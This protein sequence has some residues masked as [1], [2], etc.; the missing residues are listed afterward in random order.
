M[1]YSAK[2]FKTSRV[3]IQ[4]HNLS[5]PETNNFR[6]PAHSHCSACLQSISCLLLHF[7]SMPPHN[8]AFTLAPCGYSAQGRPG[9]ARSQKAR[10]LMREALQ[11]SLSWVAS[12]V[13]ESPGSNSGSCRRTRSLEAWGLSAVLQ[14]SEYCKSPKTFFERCTYSVAR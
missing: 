1:S 4:A 8:A 5:I 11:V 3:S 10:S 9:A 12:S 7:S 6:V 14:I 13:A 2:R